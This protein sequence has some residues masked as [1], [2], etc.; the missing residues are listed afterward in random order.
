MIAF[1]EYKIDLSKRVIRRDGEK[2]HLAKKPFDVLV[3][4]IERRGELVTREELLAE[5]WPGGQ[6]YDEAVYSCVSS[7]RKALRDLGSEPR[8]IETRWREGYRF[9]ADIDR[10]EIDRTDIDPV[11]IDRTETGP[12]ETG[13]VASPGRSLRY[14]SVAVAAVF[15]AALAWFLLSKTNPDADAEGAATEESSAP[16]SSIAVLPI[17]GLDGDRWLRRGLT[18]ELLHTISSI[19]GI[20]VVKVAGD[21]PLDDALVQ[22]LDVDALLESTLLI[23]DDLR[24]LHLRLL[25]VDDSSI[26]WSF[27]AR[28]EADQLV[29]SRAKVV[30]SL[31]NHLSAS[32]RGSEIALPANAEAWQPYLRARYQWSLRTPQSIRAAV[33]LYHEVIALDA[34]YADAHAGLAEAY[35]V[36]PLWAGTDSKEAYGEALRFARRALELDPDHAR[37]HAALAAYYA[38][39]DFDWARAEYYF[40]R[41]LELD[42]NDVTA[43]QWKADAYCYRLLFEECARHMAIAKSLDPLSPFIELLQGIPLRFTKQYVAAE[44][45][46]RDVLDRYPSLAPARFQLGIVLDAQGRFEDAIEQF[47]RIYPVYGPQLV[48]S[49]LAWGHAQL[50]NHD[51][52]REIIATLHRLNEEDF[53]SPIMMAGAALT[54]GSHD[55]V[56]R[57][58]TKAHDDNDDFFSAIAVIHHFIP[59]HTNPEFQALAAELGIPR[60]RLLDYHAS[61]PQIPDTIGVSAH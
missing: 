53:V 43:H 44:A 41:A 10:A 51:K 56:L 29:E 18:E 54:Y 61:A 55:D 23:A 32:L 57:W 42:P 59:L 60:D 45:H 15:L 39:H 19:E 48:G 21:S 12:E 9:I 11:D 22:R 52:A 47:E 13:S 17:Q 1:G 40:G 20:R 30:A 38:N 16:I 58:L 8:F 2:V 14:A 26:A 4:L 33:D 25:R 7:I 35:V 37:A 31:A 46:F 50:G 49:S 5:F 3:Y 28:Y 6:T 34:D 27:H 24:D 36:A